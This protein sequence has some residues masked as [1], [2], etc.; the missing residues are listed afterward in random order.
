MAEGWTRFYWGD[1][2]EPYSAGIEKHG[3]NPYAV[4]VMAEI[5]I[6]ISHQYSKTIEEL[7]TKD[8]DLV[9]SVCDSARE[10]CPIFPKKVKTIHKS[11]DDPPTIAKDV[12]SEDEILEIYRKVRDEI[13]R[14]VKNLPEYLT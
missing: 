12:S 9:V 6:D 13:G 2:I 8:F 5:G 10:K 3:L 14:F 7:P 1:K 4:K 11:F